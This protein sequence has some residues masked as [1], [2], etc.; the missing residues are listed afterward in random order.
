MLTLDKRYA[1]NEMTDE[2]ANKILNIKILIDFA[3]PTEH[4][5]K[6]KK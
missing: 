2:T 4:E 3:I 5:H 1:G 6:K